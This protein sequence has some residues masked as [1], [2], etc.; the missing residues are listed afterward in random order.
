MI[1]VVLYNER[2][3]HKKNLAKH[4]EDIPTTLGMGRSDRQELNCRQV[5]P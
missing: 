5:C 4:E 1:K 2:E 3:K